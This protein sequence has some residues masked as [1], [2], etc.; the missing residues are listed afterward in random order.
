ML[1][2]LGTEWNGVV[3]FVGESIDEELKAYIKNKDMKERV[4]SIVKPNHENLLA[5]YTTC[6]AF[7][8]PSFSEGFGWPVIE[9]QACG[10]PV[11]ASNIEPM[12]EVSGGAA[13]LENPHNPVDFANAFLTLKDNVVKKNISDN[14]F[15]NC[16][17]FTLDNMIESYVSLYKV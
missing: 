7:V 10:A 11:I 2:A 15:Q 16:K 3:C 17:R 1:L 9:A 14:G 6:E 13:L 4:I 5:L 8:F 12:P